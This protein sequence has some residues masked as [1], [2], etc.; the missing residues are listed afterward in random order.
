MSGSMIV[1]NERY[2]QIIK[3]NGGSIVFNAKD[4]QKS[5]GSVIT[6]IIKKNIVIISSNDPPVN[7]AVGT[8]WIEPQET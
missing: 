2:N 1:Q 8:I 6:D 4:R 3:E 7:P 5:G